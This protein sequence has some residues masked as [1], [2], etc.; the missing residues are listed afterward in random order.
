ME[1]MFSHTHAINR[2]SI[3]A[4]CRPQTFPLL[5]YQLEK[6]TARLVKAETKIAQLETAF[7]ELAGKVS[8]VWMWRLDGLCACFFA[9]SN[10]WAQSIWV[11]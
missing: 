4:L 1:F 3:I 7:S 10:F 11:S 5:R 6:V 9:S 2:F 8:G